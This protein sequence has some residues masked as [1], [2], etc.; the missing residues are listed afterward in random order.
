[1]IALV[2]SVGSHRRCRASVGRDPVSGVKTTLHTTTGSVP[3]PLTSTTARTADSRTDTG[4]EGHPRE[5]S[6][7]PPS[8]SSRDS[9]A[10]RERPQPRRDKAP[11][12]DAFTGESPDILL[13]DWF[14]ALQR[15][16]DWNGWSSTETLIQLAGHLRGRAKGPS[17]VGCPLYK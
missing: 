1:M 6:S 13:D 8:P 15:A 10:E 11:P 4:L 7:R 3:V 9:E 17:G 5:A 16:A 2:I 14:P 12:V